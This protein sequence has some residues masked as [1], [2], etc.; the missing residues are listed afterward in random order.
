MGLIDITVFPAIT[1]IREVDL[2][3]ENGWTKMNMKYCVRLMITLEG[4]MNCGGL[5]LKRVWQVL[6]LYEW[7]M[8]KHLN[9]ILILGA[10]IFMTGIGMM[11]NYR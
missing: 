2:V 9:A 10:M 8:R 6:K 1:M 5:N 4:Q 3:L 11:Q 7:H